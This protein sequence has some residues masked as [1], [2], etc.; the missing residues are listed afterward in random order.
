MKYRS[1]LDDHMPCQTK[2]TR[3]I[4]R[5]VCFFELVHRTPALKGFSPTE[6][7]ALALEE[8]EEGTSYLADLNKVPDFID[9]PPV[10]VEEVCNLP[11]GIDAILLMNCDFNR[12]PRGQKQSRRQAEPRYTQVY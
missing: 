9:E 11:F 12:H 3:L 4:W 5:L 7:D 10:A 1:R 2:L 6:L 8:E